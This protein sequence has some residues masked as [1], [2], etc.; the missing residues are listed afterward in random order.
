MSFRPLLEDLTGYA[1]RDWSRPVS[2]YRIETSHPTTSA[3]YS[4][5]WIATPAWFVERGK[6]P[7]K[8][9]T[10]GETSSKS[11][12]KARSKS[13]MGATAR[14]LSHTEQSR[15]KPLFSCSGAAFQNA[16]TIQR[17]PEQ[18]PPAILVSERLA[19]A[20]FSTRL[21]APS[22]ALLI[23]AFAHALPR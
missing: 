4:I 12:Q 3:T 23:L 16:P 6:A 8:G 13:Q 20:S 18:N 9:K 15:L 14:R 19:C 22:E 1:T 10:E 11:H 2:K 7:K 17:C 21:S 5:T